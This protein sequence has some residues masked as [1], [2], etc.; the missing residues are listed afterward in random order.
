MGEDL[1]PTQETL[2]EGQLDQDSTTG[3][4]GTG[5]SPSAK[6][7]DKSS[8]DRAPRS[9]LRVVLENVLSLGLAVF[10]VLVIRS[11]VIEAF[12]IPSGSMIPTLLVGD[13][14]FVNKFAYGLIVPFTDWFGPEPV[15]IFK[16]EAP[17]RGDIIVFK[18]P[19]NEEIYYIKRIVGEP[20]ESIELR[21]K[22]VLVNGKAIESTDLNLSDKEKFLRPLEGTEYTVNSVEIFRES[23][24]DTKPT[25]MV[26]KDD[27]R[28]D[29]ANFGPV[30]VPKDHFFVLGDNRDNS[31]DSRYW[32]FVPMKNVK[33][34]A[35]V[36][37]LS[38]WMNFSDREFFF[39]P[40]RTG[41]VLE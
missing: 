19:K 26:M 35:M 41:T 20:G 12:K 24:H 9:R 16:R 22:E 31:K 40:G 37:W 8:K 17:K 5:A 3:S 18:W 11:S 33:G 10:L 30:T 36:I 14:I 28:W 32:G 6:G 38:L 4:N 27:Y 13:H 1:E 21:G 34:K 15:Y 25:I 2:P 29:W 7:T 39:R 23:H